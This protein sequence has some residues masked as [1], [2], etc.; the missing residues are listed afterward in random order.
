MSDW[1]LHDVETAPE[2]A[3]VAFDKA[4]SSF[5]MVPNLIRVLAE[6]P[7]AAEGYMRLSDMFGQSS[8]SPEEQQ[9]VLLTVSTFH[10]CTY[11]VPAHSAVARMVGMAEEHVEALRNGEPLSDDRLEAVRRF[12]RAVVENRGWVHDGELDAFLDAGFDRRNVLDVLLGVTQKT[13]SNYTNHIADTPVDEAFS[14]SVWKPE[15]EA[16]AV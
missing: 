9:V 3:E 6:S 12:T 1:R 8:L 10:E 11:C 16:A 5:D 15:R 7:Q 2:G 13:L 14:G 4:K